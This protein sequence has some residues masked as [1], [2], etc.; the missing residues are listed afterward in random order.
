MVKRG[1]GGAIVSVASTA[2]FVGLPGRGAYCA[3]KAGILG[4][5]R[6]L[7]LEVANAGIRVNAVAPGFTRTKFIEQG[8]A[9][10][11]LQEDWMVARV[12]MH[13][14]A[15]TEEIANG[16]RFLA[17]DESSYMTGQT[18][19]LDG[20]WIVQGIPDAPEWLQTPRVERASNVARRKLVRRQDRLPWRR[21]GSSEDEPC[22]EGDAPRR[23]LL[24]AHQPFQ[25][26]LR[27]G[28]AD[29]GDIAVDQRD[30][31]GIEPAPDRS[32]RR[33]SAKARRA[34]IP[35]APA[36]RARTP[37]R[38]RLPAAISAVGRSGRCSSATVSRK[39]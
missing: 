6:A 9:D 35:C 15:R 23:A 14:L 8:L 3:A 1:K 11:S 33:Q 39:P 25:Q 21:A 29:L 28:A 2:A 13:R 34:P 18:L 5:T 10:G 31:A 36:A 37:T 19:V 26:Q 7:S 24:G 12:P 17:G 27:R 38:M 20:G 32:G 4:L 22:R 16:V 30:R